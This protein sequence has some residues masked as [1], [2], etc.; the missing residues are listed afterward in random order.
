MNDRIGTCS[1]C[2]GPVVAPATMMA[3]PVCVRCGAIARSPWPEI[4]MEEQ[5]RPAPKPMSRIEDT[6]SSTRQD[7]E[8]G[9]WSQFH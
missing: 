7:D 5:P 3:V 2:G 6:P 4:P 1:L 8:K 9:W